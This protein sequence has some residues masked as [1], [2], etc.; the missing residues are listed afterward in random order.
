[1]KNLLKLLSFIAIVVSIIW[2]ALDLSFGSFLALLTSLIFFIGLFVSSDKSKKDQI[3]NIELFNEVY[4]RIQKEYSNFEKLANGKVQNFNSEN[5][6]LAATVFPYELMIDAIE[7]LTNI[8]KFSSISKKLILSLKNK[9]N[10]NIL[11]L[12]S[13]LKLKLNKYIT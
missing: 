5:H 1:M 4:Q 9:D 12:L 8:H 3:K 7:K 2:V 11:K 10:E 13:K 6:R